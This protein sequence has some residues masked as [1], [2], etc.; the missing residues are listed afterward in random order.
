MGTATRASTHQTGP[1]APRAWHSLNR[2]CSVRASAES[3]AFGSSKRRGSGAPGLHCVGV[4][5]NDHA[6][7]PTR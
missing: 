6:G 2:A 5:G 3:P 4:C 1:R 7:C